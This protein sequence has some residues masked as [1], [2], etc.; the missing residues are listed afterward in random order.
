MIQTL[1]AGSGWTPR[2]CRHTLPGRSSTGNCVEQDVEEKILDL[3]LHFISMTYWTLSGEYVDRGCMGSRP[4]SW[5]VD[6]RG[7]S[8]LRVVWETEKTLSTAGT[9]VIN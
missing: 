5:S 7:S 1:F 8:N 4:S 6:D 3:P 9:S 2:I